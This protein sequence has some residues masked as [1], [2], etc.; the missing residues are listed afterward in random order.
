MRLHEL[1]EDLS[2]KGMTDSETLEIVSDLVKVELLKERLGA[3]L[4]EIRLDRVIEATKDSSDQENASASVLGSLSKREKQCFLMREVGLLTYEK[5]AKDLGVAI[6]TVQNY[7]ER[8][9]E[10][11]NN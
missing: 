10:K 1:I 9:K 4:D 5:I 8:A 2:T 7:I 11:L 3:S 6:G